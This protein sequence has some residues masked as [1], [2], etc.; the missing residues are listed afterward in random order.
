[1]H[2]VDGDTVT[3]DVWVL[4]GQS[5]T[6]GENMAVSGVHAPAASHTHH[7]RAAFMVRVC[8]SHRRHRTRIT[9]ITHAMSAVRA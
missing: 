2:G 5:N 3:T 7:A 8:A 6:V 9:R 1:M 4:A